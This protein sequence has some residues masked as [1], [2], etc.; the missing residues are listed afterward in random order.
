[1]VEDLLWLRRYNLLCPR[2]WRKEG[3]CNIKLYNDTW[4]NKSPKTFASP[5]KHDYTILKFPQDLWTPFITLSELHTETHIYPPQPLIE[6]ID[7]NIYSPP[8]PVSLHKSL[9]TSD[10]LLLIQYTPEDTFKSYWYLVKVYVDEIEKLNKESRTTGDYYV[11]LLSRH[12]LDNN[13]CHVN[14]KWWQLW[15]EYT[16]HKKY[17]M[18]IQLN[19]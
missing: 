7:T 2:S 17:V 5:F 3:E 19:H 12:P 11:T 1:M 13:L 6:R 14:A 8:T 10:G 15:Y 9:L 4:F 16:M 18:Y